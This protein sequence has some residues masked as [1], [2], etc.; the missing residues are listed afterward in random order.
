MPTTLT[1]AQHTLYAELMERSLDAMFDDQFQENGSFV[2][3]VAKARNGQERHYFYYVGYHPGD[4]SGSPKRYSRYVGPADDPAIAARVAKFREIKA[5]RKESASIVSALAG[6]GLPRPPVVMGRIIEGLAK[7][8]VFRLRAVLV[9]TGA[10]QTYP[11]V[12]GY[13]LSQAAAQTGDVDIAQFRSIS[14]AVDDKTPPVLDVLKGIDPT[15]RAVPHVNDPLATTAYGN[16]AGF[17]LDVIAPH[18]GSDDQMGK[19]FR[20]PALD[21][22]SAEPLRFL[23]FLL[24]EPIRSVVLHGAGVS[25]NVPSPQRYAVHKLIVSTRRLADIA[26][27][28]K[29][30][31]DIAQSSEIIEALDAA[32][33]GSVVTTALSEALDRGPKWRSAISAASTRLTTVAKTIVAEALASRTPEMLQNPRPIVDGKKSGLGL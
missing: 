30:R 33:S 5:A 7:A 26:G 15:F 1:L 3:K 19:P 4:D 16:A 6:A 25:V 21:G 14:I 2:T 27:Q 22:A 23:D 13:R 28:A 29:S 8:G 9:G 18:R 24:H 12:I 31:K 10:Y 17:R 32:G 20:M 11:A